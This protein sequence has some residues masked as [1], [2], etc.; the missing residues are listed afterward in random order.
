MDMRKLMADFLDHCQ[1]EKLLNKK[2]LEAYQIDLNQYAAFTEEPFLAA[3]VSSYVEWLKESKKT[4]TVKRKVASLR[5]FFR[6]LESEGLLLDNPMHRLKF[7]F[8]EPQRPP[9]FVPLETMQKLLK[10]AYDDASMRDVAVLEMLFSAGLRVSELSALSAEDV[11]LRR[12]LVQ[13]H[14]RGK[15]ERTVTI[16]N[17]KTIRALR[18]YSNEFRQQIASSGFFFVNRSGHQLSGQSVRSIVRNYADKANLDRK[19]TPAIL[20]NSFATL[21]LEEGADLRYMQRLL[22]HCNSTVTL[23]YDSSYRVRNEIGK[24]PR[25]RMSV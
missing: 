4:K 17:M 10:A 2:T 8:E 6:Y 19:V 18:R 12:G 13:V 15:R 23:S 7:D 11:D 3:S 25:N 24:N 21:M 5:I 16:T 1:H 20:R 14:G 22:G 9:D